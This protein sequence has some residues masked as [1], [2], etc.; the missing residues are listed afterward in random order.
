MPCTGEL[1]AGKKTKEEAR[2][3]EQAAQKYGKTRSL[4]GRI[5]QTD[6]MPGFFARVDGG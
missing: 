5:A 4:K 1:G 3:N 2:L 6:Q